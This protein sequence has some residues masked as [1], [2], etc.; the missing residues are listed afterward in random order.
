MPEHIEIKYGPAKGVYR[1][2]PQASLF[3]LVQGKA[4]DELRKSIQADGQQEP[5]V[6]DN[7]YVLDG[8]NR[9]QI[10]NEL[11]METKVVQ[12]ASLH[13]E[14]SPAEWVMTQNL[15]R[16][17]LTDDQRLAI[18]AKHLD[19]CK[20][21][22]ARLDAEAA[23][24]ANQEE[25]SGDSGTH[26]ETEGG[27]PANASESATSEF[28]QKL[29]ENA[30]QRKRGRP[31]A[32]RSEAEA[33]ARATNQSRYRAE[34]LVK[35]REYLP[36]LAVAVEESRITLKDAIRK[37]KEAQEPKKVRTK[38]SR[39]WDRVQSAAESVQMMLGSKALKLPASLRSAFWECV[40]ALALHSAELERRPPRTPVAAPEDQEPSAPSKTS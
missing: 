2:H 19:W 18:M 14:L 21:L 11:G 39:G 30:D 16:R 29:A 7:E 38:A 31:R 3:P 1:V 17:H 25:D 12:F 40:A 33:L 4:R 15:Y 9:V 10:L 35:I 34:A 27:Q 8:R 22:K 13:T 24:A 26:A 28:P 20:E 23:A 5:V 6:L 37:L 36:E 32:Q